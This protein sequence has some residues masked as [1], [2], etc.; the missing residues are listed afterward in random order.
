MN[1]VLRLLAL[2]LDLPDL[3]NMCSTNSQFKKEICGND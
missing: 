3:I 1:D 2:E